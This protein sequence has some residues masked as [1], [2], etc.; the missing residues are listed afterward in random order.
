M[1][2]GSSGLSLVV[3]IDKP[4]GMSSHDVVNRVR[5]VFGERRVGHTGTLDPLATGVLPIC[6]GPATRLDS[7]LTGHDKRYLATMR[8]G[9]E[10]T[11]DDSEGH[12][13]TTGPV[14]AELEDYGFASSY[15]ERLVGD[16]IQTPPQYSA[17]KINGKKAYEIARS[18]SE[19][20]IPSRAVRII[21]SIFHEVG[22]DAS[23]DLTTW[24]FEILASKGTYIRSL[25]RD[26][27]RDLGCPAHMTDLRRLSS[28]SVFLDDCVTIEALENVGVQA[29]IDPVRALGMRLAFCDDYER[30][31]SSG[32]KLFEN[33]VELFYMPALDEAHRFSSCTST[34]IK[35]FEPP[36]DGELVSI[37]IGNHLKAIYRFDAEKHVYLPD[38]V[39]SIPVARCS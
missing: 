39:F 13:T 15:I 26:I 5:R 38:C 31:V 29:S 35:S 3:G 18:G 32:T 27:G 7:Y 34:T 9:Y 1:K 24:T 28:G 37:L 19:A 4:R 22:K 12:P 6:I 23:T 30:F 33:Q 36:C 21:E 20:D 2:R 11:T 8:F 10:T 17:V 14:P 25:V 16:H